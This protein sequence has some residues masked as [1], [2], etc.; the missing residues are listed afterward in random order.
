MLKR[1]SILSCCTTQTGIYIGGKYVKFVYIAIF[2][3]CSRLTVQ[4]KII[5]GEEIL[6]NIAN[7]VDDYNNN[8][9]TLLEIAKK[10]KK[11]RILIVSSSSDM[12]Y[13]INIRVNDKYLV[14]EMKD[15]VEGTVGGRIKVIEGYFKESKGEQ[16]YEVEEFIEFLEESDNLGDYPV[17]EIRQYLKTINY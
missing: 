5:K 11:E 8:I 9:N 4:R 2:C 1:C 12:D 6:S 10:L 7:N 15:L 14:N 3:N 17:D 13:L 16:V